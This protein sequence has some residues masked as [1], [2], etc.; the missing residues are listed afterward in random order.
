MDQRDIAATESRR[1]VR[2]FFRMRDEPVGWFPGGLLPLLG[3]LILFL[4]GA[5]SIAPDM[6]DSTRESVQTTVS[7][8]GYTGL[9]VSVDGQRVQVSGS[10]AGWRF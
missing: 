8:A 4:W 5:F 9:N 2:R 3:L 7:S 1:V 10:R 6:E